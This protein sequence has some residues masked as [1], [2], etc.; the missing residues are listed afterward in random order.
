MNKLT[1]TTII[2]SELSGKNCPLPY[3]LPSTKIQKNLQEQ[4]SPTQSNNSDIDQN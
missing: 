3:H 1:N 2:G 4:E